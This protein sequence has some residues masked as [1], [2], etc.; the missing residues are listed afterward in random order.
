MYMRAQD[1]THAI[2]TAFFGGGVGASSF[3][4]RRRVEGTSKRLES[5]L[6]KIG[7]R[8]KGNTRPEAA[9]QNGDEA[10]SLAKVTPQKKGKRGKPAAASQ[11]ST[12]EDEDED[13]VE[14]RKKPRKGAKRR[15]KQDV[16]IDD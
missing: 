3:A 4:P 16:D 9:E 1:C 14:P 5:A 2:I 8:T 7:D 12:V 6:H 10:P 13:F 15:Q 11:G